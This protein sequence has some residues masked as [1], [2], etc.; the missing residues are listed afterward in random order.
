[1]WGKTMQ[2]GKKREATEQVTWEHPVVSGQQ[3]A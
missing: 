1:M 3:Y 2:D